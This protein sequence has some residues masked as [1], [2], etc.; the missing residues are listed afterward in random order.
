MRSAKGGSK[1]PPVFDEPEKTSI[2]KKKKAKV[3]LGKP[4]N[5]AVSEHGRIRPNQMS[6]LPKEGSAAGPIEA[7]STLAPVPEKVPPLERA[8]SETSETPTDQE[9]APEMPGET[10]GRPEKAST[11]LIPAQT[12]QGPN[13]S[14]PELP[15]AP[16]PA[17]TTPAETD[18]SALTQQSAISPLSAG[19]KPSELPL[20]I[21]GNGRG[22]H[23]NTLSNPNNFAN[24]P[25]FH[26]ANEEFARNEQIIVQGVH[27][28]TEGIFKQGLTLCAVRS[29]RQAH[30]RSFS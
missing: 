24:D 15:A 13:T 7:G 17:P 25:V 2:M 5:T 30:L 20:P 9:K 29:R 1:E 18:A 27:R 3:L 11:P 10:N 28:T 26:W 23:S 12:Q 14:G 4:E 8:A 6:R 19:R 21:G 16:T 22:N